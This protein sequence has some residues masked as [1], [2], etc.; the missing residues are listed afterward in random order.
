[1]SIL[2][3]KILKLEIGSG[4]M[5]REYLQHSREPQYRVPLNENHV[6]VSKGIGCKIHF[7]HL[8]I[9]FTSSDVW[10]PQAS[11]KLR[12]YSGNSSLI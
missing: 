3:F 7:N 10:V 8:L 1:M 9:L 11:C 4:V 2:P 12:E 5:I 6:S